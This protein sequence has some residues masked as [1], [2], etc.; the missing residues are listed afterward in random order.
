METEAE[1]VWREW[2]P[3]DWAILRYRGAI[4]NSL[5]TKSGGAHVLSP[6]RRLWRWLRSLV[7]PTRQA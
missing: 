7:S 5:T 3:I 1:Q 2:H 4:G 6:K